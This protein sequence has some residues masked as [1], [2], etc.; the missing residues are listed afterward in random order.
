MHTRRLR[1]RLSLALIVASA[2]AQAGPGFGQDAVGGSPD[3]PRD[4]APKLLRSGGIMIPPELLG[5]ETQPEVSV[6]VE[7]DARGRP[8]EVEVLSVQ[9]ATER[10]AEIAEAVRQ[11]LLG[12]RYA[13]RLVDGQAVPATLSWRIR[14]QGSEGEA[15]AGPAST[16]PASTVAGGDA[17]AGADQEREAYARRILELPE[18]RRIKLLDDVARRAIGWLDEETTQRAAT[19]HFIVYADGRSKGVAETIA[20]NLEAVLQTLSTFF[21]TDVPLYPEKY[22]LVAVVYEHESQ[23]AQLRSS[24]FNYEWAAGFY[25]P[26][27]LISFHREVH[28]P[29]RLLS[30][31][32]H[33]ATHAFL[34]R[35]VVRPGTRIPTWLNEGFA[36]YIGNSRVRKGSLQL[37]SIASRELFLTMY[38]LVKAQTA[39]TMDLRFLKR[40]LRRGEAPPVERILN[41]ESTGFYG[42]SEEEV[43]MHY[44]FAWLLVHYLRH[45]NPAWGE[46]PFTDLLLYASEGYPVTPILSQRFDLDGED[47]E[48]GFRE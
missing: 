20:G 10:E 9:P 27:G 44:A 35:H 38:G 47:L 25:H 46:G 29:G 34:D 30:L 5:E 8:S 43:R 48:K 11:T 14:F 45:G 42:G 23:F 7:I 32:I 13:P 3:L 28:T 22:K 21:G 17:L 1:T 6:R 4:R 2:V 24:V 36:D 33:E 39:E 15:S 26:A 41:A 31:L 12:W 18:Q 40:T 16:G 37:G 19:P